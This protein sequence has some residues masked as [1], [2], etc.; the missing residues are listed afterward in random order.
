M[1]FGIYMVGFVVLIIGLALAANLLHVPPKWI[2]VGV[3]VMA[4]MGILSAVTTTRPKDP[5]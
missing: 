1:S 2:G 3:V 4:G 5:S